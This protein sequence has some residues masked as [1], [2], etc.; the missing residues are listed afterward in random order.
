MTPQ[1]RPIQY[2]SPEY[3]KQCKQFTPE[4]IV[5]FLED[6]RCMFAGQFAEQRSAGKK[7]Q[8]GKKI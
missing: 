2:F 8:Q 6:F 3:L 1:Q 5:Q 4:Q 7:Q